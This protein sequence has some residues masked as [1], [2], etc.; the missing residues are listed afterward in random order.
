M[1]SITMNFIGALVLLLS[2]ASAEDYE[3][4][5]TFSKIYKSKHWVQD[6]STLSGPGSNAC[7]GI[8]YL[9][10]LQHLIDRP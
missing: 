2:L 4:Q 6:K 1:K 8:K 5:D 3:Y 10:Y 9:V 7:D